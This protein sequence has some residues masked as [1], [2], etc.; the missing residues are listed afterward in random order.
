VHWN[1]CPGIHNHCNFNR[2]NGCFNNRL[3]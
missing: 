2:F 1:N 3:G